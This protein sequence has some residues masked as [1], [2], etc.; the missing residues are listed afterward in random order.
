MIAELEK[1]PVE[2]VEKEELSL[3]SLGIFIR[4]LRLEK[5]MTQL[6]LSH[7]SN[8]D[9][10][11][12]GRL[13]NGKQLGSVPSIIALARALDIRPGLLFDVL[14]DYQIEATPEYNESNAIRLPDFFSPEERQ[15]VRQKVDDI[16]NRRVTSHMT[17]REKEQTV[18]E[19]AGARQDNRRP[20]AKKK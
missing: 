7:L 4:T 20:P 2:T 18:K 13:E 6:E 14:A 10:A 5:N 12:I 16:V 15:E 17:T 1:M 19:A 8:L 9:D 11:Y 3:K